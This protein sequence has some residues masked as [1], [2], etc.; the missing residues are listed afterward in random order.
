M[1]HRQTGNGDG[2]MT[3]AA[4][5]ERLGQLPTRVEPRNDPWPQ[6]LSRISAQDAGRPTASSNWLRL[7]AAVALAFALG[8]FLGRSWQDT[9]PGVSTTA[10]TAQQSSPN[11]SMTNL[12]GTLAGAEREYQAAFTEFMNIGKAAPELKPA[13]LDAIERDWQ[14]MLDAESALSAALEQYPNNPWLNKRMLELRERQLAMLRQLAGL[15]RTSR[16]TQ[17]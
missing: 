15:D 13:T 10:L 7:A 11:G 9:V 4:L 12:G 2:G 6:I 17:I 3:E 8:I 1:T 5:I 14:E 16:R